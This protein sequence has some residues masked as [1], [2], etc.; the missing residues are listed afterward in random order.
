MRDVLYVLMCYIFFFDVGVW[1][2]GD[3]VG[4]FVPDLGN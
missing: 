1:G 3:L 2:E 4:N